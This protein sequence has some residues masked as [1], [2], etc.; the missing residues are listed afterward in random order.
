MKGRLWL[1][2]PLLLAACS[3][4]TSG[5]L[6]QIPYSIGGPQ[7]ADGGP[8]QFTTAMGW[9][10]TLQAAKI[11]LGPFYFN[12]DP[13]NTSQFRDGVVIVEALRQVTLDLLDPTLVPVPGGAQG[14]LGTAKAAEIDLLPPDPTIS[15]PDVVGPTDTSSAY[16]SGVAL[17]PVDGGLVVPFQGWITINQSL[18]SSSSSTPLP[19]LQRV[20]GAL[21]N[22]DFSSGQQ[23]LTLRVDPTS[24]F[25]TADFSE[26][27]GG[28]SGA[29]ALT[30]DGGYGWDTASNFHAAVL[31]QIQAT[32]GVYAFDLSGDGG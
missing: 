6:L 11:D 32:T 30:G 29:G 22:L 25:D 21:C 23:S 5:G 15:D 17:G 10:V 3:N 19:W 2:L 20:N 7:F 26:L 4:S 14:E 16:F 31:G 28:A 1:G 13:P 8:L 24:W 9:N 18:T 27:P 12:I